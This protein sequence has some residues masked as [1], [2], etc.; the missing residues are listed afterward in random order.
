[1]CPARGCPFHDAYTSFTDSSVYAG[2]AMRRRRTEA[3][4]ATALG[5]A[6]RDG[7]ALRGLSEATA[8]QRAA[9]EAAIQAAREEGGAGAAAWEDLAQV[10][11]KLQEDVAEVQGYTN[12]MK[13]WWYIVRSTDGWRD[14]WMDAGMEG[15]RDG[16]TDGQMHGRTAGW[17]DGGMDEWKATK[18]AEADAEE[19]CGDVA[20]VSHHLVFRGLAAAARRA[21]AFERKLQRGDLI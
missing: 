1:M 13:L 8:E 21:A 7:A 10:W 14:G 5:H 4:G 15:W 19:A 12:C 2:E 20:E 17:M 18:E 6:L 9:C 16:R 11:G 3:S